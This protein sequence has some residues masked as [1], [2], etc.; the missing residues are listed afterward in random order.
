LFQETK[1][2]QRLVS[3]LS[4]AIEELKTTV[5]SKNEELSL[6][7]QRLDAMNRQIEEVQSQLTLVEQKYKDQQSKNS[8]DMK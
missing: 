3:D 6:T 8:G 4:A 5:T 2:K 7:K 1:A